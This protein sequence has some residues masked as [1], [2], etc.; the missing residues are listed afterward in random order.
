M[1]RNNLLYKVPVIIKQSQMKLHMYTKIIIYT[2]IKTILNLNHFSALL[3][4][5][6]I[7][8]FH[9]WRRLQGDSKC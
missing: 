5:P 4:Q 7:L 3:G 9:W 8:S 1:Y 6:S 2:K